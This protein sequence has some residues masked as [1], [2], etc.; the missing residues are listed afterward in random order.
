MIPSL[1]EFLSASLLQIKMVEYGFATQGQEIVSAFADQVKGKT[2]A[3]TVPS[4]GGIG[5]EIA[6]S[7]AKASSARLIPFGRSREKTQSV[8]NSI[9]AASEQASP[10]ETDFIQVELASLAS[11]RKA[12]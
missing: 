12:A 11:V 5:A 6:I 3:I 1:E 8:I 10:I 9:A 7:L 2:F 4:E